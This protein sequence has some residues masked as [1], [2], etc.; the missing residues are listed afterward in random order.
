MNTI[1]SIHKA[2]RG[3]RRTFPLPRSPFPI[4][5]SPLSIALAALCATTAYAAGL[6]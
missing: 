4:P 5:P 2:M 3:I 6:L 1:T